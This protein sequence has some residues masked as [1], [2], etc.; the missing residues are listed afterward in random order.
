MSQDRFEDPFVEEIHRI[1]EKL[2]EECGGDIE[3]LM[4]RLVAR[5]REDR[6]HVMADLQEAKAPSS[7]RN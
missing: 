1:R 2:L 3:K 6:S 7:P 4:D 5:E